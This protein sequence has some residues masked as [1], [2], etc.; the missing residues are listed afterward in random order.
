MNVTEEAE[1]VLFSIADNGI[2]IL[3]SMQTSIFENY[4]RT[5]RGEK[6]STGD[7]IGLATVKQL[8]ELHQGKIKVESEVNKGSN[9]T[10]FIPKGLNK[11]TQAETEKA[12]PT[13]PVIANP[14]AT[15][16]ILIIDDEHDTVN[17]LERNLCADFKVLKAY[18]GKEGLEIAAKELP[19]IIVTDLMMPN[20]DGMQ[21]LRTLK[22]DK[23]LQHI[24]VII[25][26]AKT[27]EEDMLEAFDN[28]ADAY[29]TKPISLKLLRKRIDRLIEQGENTQLTADITNKTKSSYN[30]E[31]QIFL[32]RC[33]EVI[34]N[35]LQN[36]DLSID[37]IADAMAMSHSSLY[38]KIKGMTGM[39]LIDF[40]N[41]YKIYK[42]VEMFRQGATNVETVRMKCG[43]NDAK[44]FRNIFKRKK[45]VTPKQFV[46]DLYK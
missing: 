25:F 17:I 2:G 38:K 33:R 43:F 30:K 9:F 45:G 32:L 27:A 23:K 13:A 46:Q 6:Q 31:E 15:H 4:F 12:V 39:S 21:F 11:S 24:K 36:S 29:L 34:D 44:N 37:L 1:C 16:S 18:D 7:G 10:F 20:I 42:A 5:K 19:D 28:G 35:N 41:D 8:V 3:E 22:E 40:I 14:A 26:T